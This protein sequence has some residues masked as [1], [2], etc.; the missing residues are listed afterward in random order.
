MKI[1]SAQIT[2]RSFLGVAGASV[3]ASVA[4]ATGNPLLL[5][6]PMRVHVAVDSEVSLKALDCTLAF[7][8]L[9]VQTVFS[10][11]E[12]LRASVTRSAKVGTEPSTVRLFSPGQRSAAFEKLPWLIFGPWL[13]SEQKL[14]SLLRRSQAVYIDDPAL[15]LQLTD[16]LG[17]RQTPARSLIG[18]YSSF[19]Q[20]VNFASLRISSNAMGEVRDI[21]VNL[22]LQD[23]TNALEAANV[24]RLMA[25]SGSIPSLRVVAA[26]SARPAVHI[27]CKRGQLRIPLYSARERR[28][29]LP[30][31]LQHFVAVARGEVNSFLTMQDAANTLKLPAKRYAS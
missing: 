12:L 31:R 22:H 27:S 8:E 29:T 1:A 21:A 24:H 26:H 7:S 19:D 18:L 4:S 23:T 20:I 10:S 6:S 2:R 13:G 28:E 30:L 11:S 17:S 5:R 25:N 3:V 15:S 9:C 16:I 14:I